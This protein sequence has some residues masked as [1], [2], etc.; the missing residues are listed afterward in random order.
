MPGDELRK[1][2]FPKKLESGLRPLDNVQEL[3]RDT[4]VKKVVVSHVGA[5]GKRCGDGFPFTP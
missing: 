2:P 1:A 3:P 5:G 4:V